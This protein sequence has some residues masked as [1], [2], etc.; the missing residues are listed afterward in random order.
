VLARKQAGR[1]RWQATLAGNAGRQRWQATLV[2][3]AGRRAGRRA[4][5]PAWSRRQGHARTLAAFVLEKKSMDEWFM[6][7]ELNCVSLSTDCSSRSV[8]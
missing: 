3:N 5:R 7:V 2:G 8:Q 1:Q 4:G 6:V